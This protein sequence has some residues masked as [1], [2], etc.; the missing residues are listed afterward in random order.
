M[1]IFTHPGNKRARNITN[2]GAISPIWPNS[3]SLIPTG[4][5]CLL[6]KEI[7]RKIDRFKPL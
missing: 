6:A 5:N 1:I 4:K 3:G 2:A 7:T